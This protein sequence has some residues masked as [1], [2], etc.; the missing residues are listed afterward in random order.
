MNDMK[1]TARGTKG[2]KTAAGMQQ[3][4]LIDD[5]KRRNLREADLRISLRRASGS[6]KRQ[7][8]G[9]T[10]GSSRTHEARAKSKTFLMFLTVETEHFALGRR[11]LALDLVRG[12]K[13]RA[14]EQERIVRRKVEDERSRQV[15][16]ATLYSLPG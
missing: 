1:E 15:I 5:L 6:S 9:E 14:A 2:G 12:F 11:M 16:N 7:R 13:G 4:L 8:G 10:G 3:N